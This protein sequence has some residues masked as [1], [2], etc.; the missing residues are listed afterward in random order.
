[1]ITKIHEGYLY[2]KSPNLFQLLTQRRWF[3]L[4]THELHYSEFPNGN[5]A[6]TICMADVQGL[7]PSSSNP[8][9]FK[10][11]TCD[12]EYTV[13]ADNVHEYGQWIDRLAYVIHRFKYPQPQFMLEGI[14]LTYFWQ[15]QP[16]MEI[17]YQPVVVLVV[18]APE[19][20]H[21]GCALQWTNPSTMQQLTLPV[22]D[23]VSYDRGSASH[24]AKMLSVLFGPDAF[25]ARIQSMITF[26]TA[27]GQGHSFESDSEMD[28][29]SWIEQLVELQAQ[30]T[31]TSL[32]DQE[33]ENEIEDMIELQPPPPPPSRDTVTS[34]NIA[35]PPPP[36]PISIITAA[37][38]AV[39][40]NN[41]ITSMHAPRLS[42]ST[43]IHES[44]SDKERRST[45][46]ALRHSI[47]STSS[48]SGGSADDRHHHETSL[49]SRSSQQQHRQEQSNII[50]SQVGSTTG[51]KTVGSN[52]LFSLRPVLQSLGPAFEK[53]IDICEE[54]AI[55][56]QFLREHS[57]TEKHLSDLGILPVHALRVLSEV[58][59]NRFMPDVKLPTAPRRKSVL[60]R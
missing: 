38:T 11:I 36:L 49:V 60:M 3:T 32:P 46:R 54:N 35:S 8:C 39:A 40:T 31:H 33:D 58:R 41:R 23:I 29:G 21:A 24:L 52:N 15:N 18:P 14:R 42:L 57:V 34:H 17:K 20:P 12:R 13:T 37:A 56:Q 44:L 30:R 51:A 9:R 19:S 26:E 1:M 48:G 2:K 45:D 27:N 53:Y 55:D 4:D 47:S 22:S 6:N 50:N 43:I 59:K 28:L 10:I 7:K 16:N 25:G 5:N